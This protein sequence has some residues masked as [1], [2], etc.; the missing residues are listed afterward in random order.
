ATRFSATISGQAISGA[1]SG[2]I[3]DAFGGGGNLFTPGAN[4][5]TINFAAEQQSP[6][7]R[8]TDEAFAALGYAQ[9]SAGQM[10]VKAPLRAFDRDW[11]AW[12]DVRGTGFDQND[13]IGSHGHQLNVTAGVGR[14][15]TPDLLVGA[16]AGYETFNFTMESIAG[17]MTG[18]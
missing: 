2:A 11:S 5:F 7:A 9:S 16:Y 10:P 4:G 6:V 17:R 8:R 18:D 13:A 14:K 12:A 3:D 1:V 15:L